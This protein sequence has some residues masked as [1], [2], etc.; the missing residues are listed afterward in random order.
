[1]IVFNDFS[2]IKEIL[3]QIEI[4]IALKNYDEILDIIYLDRSSEDIIKMMKNG[5]D[6]YG[7]YGEA[8]LLDVELIP[9]TGDNE[10]DFYSAIEIWTGED[11]GNY[12]HRGY[13]DS[14]YRGYC[15]MN[16]MYS[17]GVL[18]IFVEFNIININNDGFAL[19]FL[20]VR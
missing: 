9:V 3:K 2:E 14:D 6:S 4:C 8:N 1:M 17:E 7:T 15:S 18:D 16:L 19:A 13:G 11:D 20:D 12:Y 5:I 10:A